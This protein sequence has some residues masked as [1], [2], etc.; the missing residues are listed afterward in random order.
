MASL[1][2]P[3][4]PPDV[5]TKRRSGAR[6][7]SRARSSRT[8]S[9]AF[10]RL[11]AVGLGRLLLLRS[12]SSFE[13]PTAVAAGVR[14]DLSRRSSA[15]ASRAALDALRL[16][17]PD[18]AAAGDSAD[19]ADAGR[20]DVAGG[21]DRRLALSFQL[22]DGASAACGARR[23]AESIVSQL[24]LTFTVLGGLVG[25]LFRD[26]FLPDR[27]GADRPD[28]NGWERRRRRRSWRCCA[29]SSTRI[30]CSTRSI[31]SRRWCCSS[32]P[33]APMRCCRGLPIFLRYHARSTSRPRTSP[34]RRRWRR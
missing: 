23:D 22:I 25:A 3:A 17:S 9:K 16:L 28:A 5:V 13:R 12:V 20:G 15:I 1:P 10:W 18:A 26:Q 19:V 21:D 14:P 2:A 8:S 24:F 34:S 32:R 11:Q 27:R 31:R 4:D 29:T 30:S 7:S 6:R 33:S